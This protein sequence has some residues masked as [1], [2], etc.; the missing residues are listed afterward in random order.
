MLRIRVSKLEAG[1]K[2][3]GFLKK[4]IDA[5]FHTIKTLIVNDK[6]RIN[7]SKINDEY[8]L[9]K[10]D[11]FSIRDENICMKNKKKGVKPLNLKIE[12]IFEDEYILVLNKPAGLSVQENINQSI[13]LTNHLEF[14]KQKKSLDYLSIIHRLDKYT[15]GVIICAKSPKILRELHLLL[16]EKK[17]NKNYKSLVFGKLK[18]KKLSVELFLNVSDDREEKVRVVNKKKTNRDKYSLSYF[19]VEN[20]FRFRNNYYSLLD[21]KIKTGITHQIRVH[22]KYLGFPIIG[23]I[24]YGN[25]KQNEIFYKLNLKRQFLHS[26]KTEFLYE[27]KKYS[28]VAKLPR[29]LNRIIS[30]LEK[31]K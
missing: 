5:D 20:E 6:I 25:K 14:L 9:K 15:S 17:F 10:N 2:P 28:L 29:E 27:G 8:I 16:K 1:V 11:V 19:E 26:Y 18:H 3:I 7:N 31:K 22:M 21:V 12:E 23:D 4:K 13:S 30:I 24:K